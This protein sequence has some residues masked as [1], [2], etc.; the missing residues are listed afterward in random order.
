[1]LLGA[2]RDAQ[3]LEA[4]RMGHKLFDKDLIILAALRGKIDTGSDEFEIDVP[5]KEEDQQ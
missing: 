5:V 4:L 3:A 1:L 2:T